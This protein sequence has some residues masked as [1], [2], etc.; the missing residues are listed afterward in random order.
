MTCS[1]H[2]HKQL[3]NHL[4]AIHPLLPA[5]GPCFIQFMCNSSRWQASSQAGRNTPCIQ[6]RKHMQ[7]CFT[8]AAGSCSNQLLCCSSLLGQIGPT[9]LLLATDTPIPQPT[10][11]WQSQWQRWQY[12]YQFQ[13]G[14]CTLLRP[15]MLKKPVLHAVLAHDL[16]SAARLRKQHATVVMQQL[17]AWQA[18][19][20][21]FT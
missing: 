17:L 14:K 9:T 6:L 4:M 10:H 16:V 2:H 15:P 20:V 7:T 8:H 3:G 19:A 13:L 11:V 1:S 18:M 12:K 21:Q 5:E